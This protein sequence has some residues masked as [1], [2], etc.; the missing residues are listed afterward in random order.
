MGEHIVYGVSE[1][2]QQT[3][4]TRLKYLPKEV[5]GLVRESSGTSIQKTALFAQMARFNTLYMV[6]KAGSGHLG[7]SFSSLDIM[8]WLYLNVL[9]S[10]DRFFSSKGH[11]SPGL[12]SVQTAIGILPFEKIHGLRQLDGLPGHPDVGTRGAFTNTGSLGMGVSKAKGFIFSDD[13]SGKYCGR[14]YVLTGDGELQEGQFWESLMS[15]T[16]DTKNRL[17]VIVD[18]NKV[19]SDSFVS[20]VGDLGDLKAKFAAFDCDVS[21]CDGHDMT[22]LGYLFDRSVSATRTQVIIA[23]TRKGRGVSF[24][25]HTSMGPGEEYYR[26]H[27][28]APTPEDYARA[29]KELLD[30]IICKATAIGINEVEPVEVEVAPLRVPSD[31]ERMIPA[32][33]ESILEEAAA[34][35]S[36]VALDADLILDTGLIPFRKAH[37]ERFIECGIAEQDMVSRAG[38]M[39]LSG[40][41]PV[42]HSFA[43]FLTSRA[44][45]QIYNNCTERTKVIYTGALAGLLPGGP[46]H[47]HQAVRD[48]AAMYSMPGVTIIEPASVAQLKAAIRWAVRSNASS[49]YLRVTSIPFQVTPAQKALD[50]LREGQGHVLRQGQHA[51]VVVAGPIMTYQALAAADI[52]GRDGIQVKIISMPWL[53]R[54]DMGWF[55]AEISDGIALM[56]LENHFVESG[57]G[58]ILTSQLAQAGLLGKRTVA[59]EGVKEIPVC[60]RNDEVLDYHGLTAEKIAIKIRRLVKNASAI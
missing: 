17:T 2:I 59:I 27:S 29:H 4:G 5:F 1:A 53:N 26:F 21:R 41:L 44:S 7:S 49:T 45:E 14:V 48:V 50:H 16:R 42:V 30:D 31:A 37:P 38:T 60:G 13:L 12:Y 18:H 43:C 6:S 10:G 11:D 35:Q 46:G 47:S 33:S 51:L 23:D 58:A 15:A 57:F 28:G 9:K 55:Q 34:N 25:E 19:Q 3:G 8:S 40:L 20:S 36:L 22:T 52:L 39:A 32:Y 56:T 54:F 24:M